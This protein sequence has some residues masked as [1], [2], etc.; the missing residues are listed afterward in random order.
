LEETEA[1]QEQ[2]RL[3]A[4]DVDGTLLTDKGDLPSRS[5][6]LLR[7]ACG[8]GVHIVIST[9]RI[10][11]FTDGICREIGTRSPLICAN[12][13]EVFAHPG[14]SVWMRRTIPLDLARRI[15]AL[16]DEKGWRLWTAFGD[17]AFRTG[18]SKSAQTKMP[19]FITLVDKNL[20]AMESE[21]VSIF[22]GDPEA[23]SMLSEICAEDSRCRTDIYYNP[24]GDP[25]S[26]GVFEKSADKGTALAYVAGRL[27]VPRGQTMAIGDNLNDVPMFD[28]A[29]VS[30]AMGN[31]IPSIKKAARFVA[32]TNNHGGV[33]WAL[34]KFL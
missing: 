9:T 34:E 24:E 12:G 31:A 19:D 23:I 3:V 2:I 28:H 16:S 4:I 33:A 14:G 32:P 8:N 15:A 5:V 30:V 18:D 22:A 1:L 20:P 7:E 10:A 29:G 11:P 26:I 6:M 21:P 27:G 17:H 25:I 13:A